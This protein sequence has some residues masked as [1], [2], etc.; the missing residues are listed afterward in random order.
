MLKTPPVYSLYFTNEL[1]LKLKS[2]TIIDASTDDAACEAAETIVAARG[3]AASLWADMVMI[4]QFP[5]EALS[6]SEEAVKRHSR[7]LRVAIRRVPETT[8]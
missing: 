8:D 7:A 6:E 3:G 5:A 2:E 4:R 1:G